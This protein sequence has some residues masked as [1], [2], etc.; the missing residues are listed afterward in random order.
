MLPIRIGK[1]RPLKKNEALSEIDILAFGAHPDDVELGCGGSIAK[2][3]AQGKRVG[4][5][6]LT[7]GELGTRGTPEI[8]AE[9]AKSSATLLQLAFRENLR[10]RDGFFTNDEVHQR[11]VIEKIRTYRPKV[12]LCNA[13]EDRHIDHGRGSQLVRDACFLS[14]L[15]K[16]ETKAPPGTPQKAW[17]PKWVLHYI[18]WNEVK[19]HIIIDIS[20]FLETKMQAVKS[21]SSQFYVP[22]SKESDTPIS[23]ANFLDS[24]AYRARNLGRLIGVEAGEGFTTSQPLAVN[25]FDSLL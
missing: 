6:D 13:H 20:G 4:I 18:Q 12:V 7:R 14:G 1:E 22:E 21:F 25:D 3:V 5:I 17:R 8:R 11:K 16:V 15:E 19:P 9:E 23:S 10:F 2:S 24:I